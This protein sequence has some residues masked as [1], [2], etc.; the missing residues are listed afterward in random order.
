MR[1]RLPL[2]DFDDISLK[3]IVLHDVESNERCSLRFEM[4][5]G[6]KTPLT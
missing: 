5:H 6:T 3:I 2:L 4:T 1:K